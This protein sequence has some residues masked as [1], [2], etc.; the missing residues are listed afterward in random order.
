MELSSKTLAEVFLEFSGQTMFVLGTACTALGV[1]YGVNKLTG[2]G[3]AVLS[4]LPRILGMDQ[5][6]DSSEKIDYALVKSKFSS[7]FVAYTKLI[8]LVIFGVA[9]KYCGNAIC[10]KDIILFFNTLLYRS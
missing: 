5:K 8:I 2:H 9:I 6:S 4:N 7:E 1:L 3:I 10:S